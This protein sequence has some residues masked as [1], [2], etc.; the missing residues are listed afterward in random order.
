MY[1]YIYI[2]TL[3]IYI[4]VINHHICIYCIYI[5][6]GFQSIPLVTP[7]NHQKSRSRPQACGS[8]ASAKRGRSLR[9]AFS[10][11]PLATLGD[12]WIYRI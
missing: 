7:E 6:D 4:I 3:Y 11:G 2:Y 5:Y 1:I 12:R 10:W 8:E 9:S